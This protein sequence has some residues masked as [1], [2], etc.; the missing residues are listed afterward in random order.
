[1]AVPINANFF[2]GRFHHFVDGEFHK[3]ERAIRRGVSDGVAENDGACAVSNG[4]CI[5]PLHS[6]RIRA[7]GVFRYVH[8]RKTVFDSELDRFFS[9]ALEVIN[10]PVFDQ[11]ADRTGAEKRCGF[12]GDANPLRNFHDRADVVFMR[13]RRAVGLDLHPVSGDFAGQRF[14]VCKSARAGARQTDI[15]RADSE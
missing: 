8:G 4:G 10:G 3:V 12:N 7:N 5:Q 15:D 11:A 13:A 1:M 6:V 14:G 2:T 9:G